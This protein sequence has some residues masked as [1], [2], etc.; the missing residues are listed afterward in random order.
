[1]R[2]PI[3]GEYLLDEKFAD[4]TSMYLEGTMPNLLRFKEAMEVFCAASGAKI[5][6][7]K[8]CGLWA[9]QSEPP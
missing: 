2:L 8:S 4:N 5:N 7:H 6:W 1:M 3:K 9:G